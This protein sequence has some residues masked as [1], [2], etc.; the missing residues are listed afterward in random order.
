MI[1]DVNLV[2]PE[3][4]ELPI[5]ITEFGMNRPVNPVHAEKAEFPIVLTEF[6]KVMSVKPLQYLKAETLYSY[7]L[8]KI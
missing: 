2:H 3:K 1:S 5:E 4:A 6:S 8:S 7:F